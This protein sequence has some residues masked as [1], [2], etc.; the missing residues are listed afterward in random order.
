MTRRRIEPYWFVIIAVLAVAAGLFIYHLATR[1]TPPRA[2]FTVFGFSIYWYGIWIVTGIALGAW[3]AARLAEGRARRLFEATVPADVRERPLAEV[4]MPDDLR[5]LLTSR[6]DPTLGDV[7]WNYGLDPRRLGL[8]K[9]PTAAVGAALATAPG[10]QAEWLDDAPWRQWNPDH[11]WNGLIYVLILGVIGARLYHILTPSPSMAAV[12]IYSPLDYFRNPYQLLNFRGGGLG[13]YGAVAGGLLGLLIYTRRARIS[14]LAWADLAVVGLALGQAIGR[15]GNFFNQELY[16]K[17]TDL[18]W[19]IYIDPPY[20][21][22]DYIDFNYFHP[23]FLYESLWSLGTFLLLYWLA[24]RKSD[25]LLPGEIMALYFVAYAIGRS[26]L[27]LVRLDS[28]VIA[29]F[30]LESGLA[31]ATVVS[32]VVAVISAVWVVVRRWRRSRAQPAVG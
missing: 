31:V 18:P 6:K 24:K 13:I 29:F 10:V 3:V 4:E 28:R 32:I 11:V 9:E 27:E 14:T 1:F 7:L 8:K 12:G 19:A 25:R 23:A 30:G 21:L 26:L 5:T 2:A 16:G 17:P 22:P 15:W 20:R